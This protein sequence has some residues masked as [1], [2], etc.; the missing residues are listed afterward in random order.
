LRFASRDLL[1]EF[2]D[3]HLFIRK[4]LLAAYWLYVRILPTPF[5]FDALNE[6]DPLELSRFVFD[7][8]KLEWLGYNLVK[9][10]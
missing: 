7:M 5:P 1:A 4:Q 6:R 8:G 2:S 9:I 3:S 10:A